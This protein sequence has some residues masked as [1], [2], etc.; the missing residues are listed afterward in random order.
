[1]LQ[2]QLRELALCLSVIRATCKIRTNTPVAL[3]LSTYENP[4]APNQI[5]SDI[6]TCRAAAYEYKRSSK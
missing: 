2:N 3:K 6:L 1:M 4:K 5:N